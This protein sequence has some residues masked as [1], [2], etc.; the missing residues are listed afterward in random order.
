MRDSLENYWPG[1]DEISRTPTGA[2]LTI[3]F[4][5]LLL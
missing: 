2:A 4:L 3:V 5:P 1:P